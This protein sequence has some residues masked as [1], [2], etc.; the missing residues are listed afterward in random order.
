L[1]IHGCLVIALYSKTAGKNAKHGAVT[2]SSTIAAVSN[3]GVQLFEHMYGLEFRVIPEATSTFL[4]KQFALLWPISFLT[5]MTSNPQIPVRCTSFELGTADHQIFETLRSGH[6]KFT[7][8]MKLF[9]QR[10][11]MEDDGEE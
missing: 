10:K 11:Q 7:K 4:T 2:D 3:I 8:A 9:A 6:S 5:L 1:C